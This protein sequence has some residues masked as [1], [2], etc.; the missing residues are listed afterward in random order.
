VSTLNFS[1]IVLVCD[2]CQ[3]RHGD[4]HGH[5]S[6][7][8]ARIAAYTDGWRFPATVRADGSP[9]SAACDVCPDCMPTWQPQHYHARPGRSTHL[10]VDKAPRTEENQ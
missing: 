4:P 3:K 9:G 1:R 10:H 2:G 7:Q 8:E 6:A 5:N